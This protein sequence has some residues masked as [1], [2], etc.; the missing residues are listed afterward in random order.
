M[1]RTCLLLEKSCTLLFVTLAI[2]L[3][4]TIRM[5][6]G[7]GP[8]SEESDLITQLWIK[9]QLCV[10][11]D[12]QCEVGDQCGSSLY[13][14]IQLD[15]RYWVSGKQYCECIDINDDLFLYWKIHN[16]SFTL[17]QHLFWLPDGIN[18]I[19]LKSFTFIQLIYFHHL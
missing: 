4:W 15:L 19:M 10:T 3:L 13:Q 6:T 12:H 5:F 16:R 9:K 1:F 14:S 11:S 8:V 2:W 17:K 18:M 7:S